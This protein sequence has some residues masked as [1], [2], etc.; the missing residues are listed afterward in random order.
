MGC[1][2]DDCSCCYIVQFHNVARVWFTSLSEAMSIESKMY[3][4]LIDEAAVH[5]RR[6]HDCNCN[7]AFRLAML[8]MS[9]SVRLQQSVQLRC[10]SPRERLRSK[11]IRG[12]ST[13]S[14]G[15]RAGCRPCSALGTAMAAFARPGLNRWRFAVLSMKAD[16][17]LYYVSN[18]RHEPCSRAMLCCVS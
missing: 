12:P 3:C 8:N 6:M 5:V 15:T 17:F 14:E 16:A 2:A 4:S 7:R 10:R 1:R 9:Y 18:S 11:R 13:C